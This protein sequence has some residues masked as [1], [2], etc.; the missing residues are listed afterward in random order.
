MW[1]GIRD[2]KWINDDTDLF[3]SNS[4]TNWQLGQPSGRDHCV[5]MLGDIRKPQ[6]N[7]KWFV[8]DCNSK[9]YAV[10]CQIDQG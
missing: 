5:V 2:G 10:V 8:Y 7:G 4:F 9:H 1:L 6:D 3:S